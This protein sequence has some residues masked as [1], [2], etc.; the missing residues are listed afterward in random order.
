MVGFLFQLAQ[1]VLPTIFVLYT[2]Y[3]YG[4]TPKILGLTFMASGISQILVQA[5]L[6]GPVVRRIGERGAVLLGAAFGTL[7]FLAYGLA[8]E[9]WIYLC[10]IPIFAMV[11]FLQPGVM[12]LMSRRVGPR[13]QGRLQGVNQS[14]MG[15]SSIIGPP[16]YG[17]TFAWSIRNASTMHLPGL[18]DL[19]RGGLCWPAPFLLALRVAR[20][21]EINCRSSR[22]D[23][24][25]ATVFS[26]DLS[27]DCAGDARQL[28]SFQLSRGFG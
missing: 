23:T 18:A 12:G 6:V 13:E 20:P 5:L 28:T 3:R 27:H 17:L 24:R 7:G 11:G 16:L 14:F 9:P 22:L 2:G 15:V 8:D 25:C 4:W 1:V 21:P 10:A 26:V 19:D